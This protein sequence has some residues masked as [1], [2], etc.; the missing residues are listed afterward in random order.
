M[1]FKHLYGE[2]VHQNNITGVFR[3]L[4]KVHQVVV[5]KKENR[6]NLGLNSD[7]WHAK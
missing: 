1:I 6:W 5:A 3:V 2:H 4:P 7:C